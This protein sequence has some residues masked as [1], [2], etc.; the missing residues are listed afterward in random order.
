MISQRHLCRRGVVELEWRRIAGE[1]F[2]IKTSLQAKRKWQKQNGEMLLER[3][4]ILNLSPSKDAGW[5]SRSNEVCLRADI[6]I[7]S[8]SIDGPS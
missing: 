5:W 3:G 4:A 1:G 8:P 6:R 2:N 7:S